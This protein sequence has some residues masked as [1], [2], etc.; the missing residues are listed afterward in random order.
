MLD[1]LAPLNDSATQVAVTGERAFLARLEGGCLV[2][3]AAWGRLE[4]GKL[5]LEALIS[6]LEGKRFLQ[7][8]LTGSLEDAADLGRRLAEMLLE[9]GGREIL[10]EIY[11]KAL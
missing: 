4:D 2:P 1:L 9:R 5:T 11:G 10:Q 7:D 3:V 8:S 6:D